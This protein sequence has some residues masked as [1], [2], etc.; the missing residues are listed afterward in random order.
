MGLIGPNGS[1]KSTL[2]RLLAGDEVPDE[3][4]VAVTSG[5][6]VAWVAQEDVFAKDLTARQA[7][8]GA[9]DAHLEPHERMARAAIALGKVGFDEPEAPSADQPVDTLSGGW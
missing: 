8:E 7:V 3:G 6:R 5:K 9:L 4:S 1:G 2:L